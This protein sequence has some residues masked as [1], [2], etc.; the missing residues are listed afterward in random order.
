[1]KQLTL[2]EKMY[3]AGLTECIRRK[4]YC[5]WRPCTCAQDVLCCGDCEFKSSGCGCEYK[6]F[7]EKN[8]EGRNGKNKKVCNGFNC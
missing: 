4:G 8:E 7:I 3:E 5:R 1:M 6:A 2:A